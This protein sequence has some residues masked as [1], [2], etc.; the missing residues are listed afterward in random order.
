MSHLFI[1][2]ILSF[3]WKLILLKKKKNL[4]AKNT[5]LPAFCIDIIIKFLKKAHLKIA[6]LN[7]FCI[8]VFSVKIY[9]SVT[10]WVTPVI[11]AP[12]DQC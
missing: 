9:Y 7:L 2:Y 12:D 3:L 1:F 8:T 6:S 5:I 11:R 10:V 4:C